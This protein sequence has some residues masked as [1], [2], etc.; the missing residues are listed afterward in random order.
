MRNLFN[1]FWVGAVALGLTLSAQAAEKK[2][3]ALVQPGKVHE[4]CIALDFGQ[5]LEYGFVSRRAMNFNIHYH[6]G[7]NV[8]YPVAEHLT[9]EKK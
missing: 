1:I 7:D 4:L 6:E 9:R 8:S 3:R 5:K 2:D